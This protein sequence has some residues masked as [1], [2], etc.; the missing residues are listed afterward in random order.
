MERP[1]SRPDS[2]GAAGYN[3]RPTPLIPSFAGVTGQ[4]YCHDSH[5]RTVS[6]A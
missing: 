3:R 1:S 6:A 5:Q 2:A 4:D